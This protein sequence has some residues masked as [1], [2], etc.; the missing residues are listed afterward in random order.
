MKLFSKLYRLNLLATLSIFILSSVTYYF[1]IRFV[2]LDQFD[3]NLQI[4]RVEIEKYAARYHYL[5][6]IIPVKD[7]LISF[8]PAA[9]SYKSSFET[10]IAYDTIGL[11][12]A[13]FR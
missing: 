8:S 7:R 4:E 13:D 9:G 6:E 5:P 12:T 11:D 3:E 2:V 10:V 1:L